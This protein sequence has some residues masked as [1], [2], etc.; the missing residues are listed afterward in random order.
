[1]D[2]PQ[3]A[4]VSSAGLI[5]AGQIRCFIAVVN[6]PAS[7]TPV[8]VTP[9]T[10]DNVQF[11]V[12][13]TTLNSVSDTILGAVDVNAVRAFSFTPNRSGTVTSPGTIVYTHTLSNSGNQSATVSIPA[14]TSAYGWTYQYSTDGGATWTSSVSLSLAIGA[15]AN[16]QV[17]VIVPAGEPIN[18]SEAATLTATATYASGTASAS[19]IDTTTI[20]G[21][22]LRLTKSAISYVGSTATVR[23]GT[24]AQAFPGD[25]IVYTVVSE[26][27][28]T[29]N[30]TKV[31][32]SDPLPA[33]TT[34][35]SVSATTTI[36]AGTVLYSTN[37]TTWSTTA[38]T[39]LP[40]GSVIYVGVDTNGDT[41]ITA[42]DTMPPSGKITLTLRVRV[43]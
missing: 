11:T 36:P 14:Y 32:V 2:T 10:S 1:M 21:G 13:S 37:G 43:Q 31:V 40:A 42:A 23:S 18:R 4:S 12:T 28:G 35:V 29:G 41:N 38:P 19:V 3:P 16:L 26:N 34:F 33:Y 8:D 9:G 15:T 24:A 7:A 39:N 22:D 17:R 5:N 30:L 20:V 27:I 25:E 6:V